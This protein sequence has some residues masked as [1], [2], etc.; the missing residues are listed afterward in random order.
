MNPLLSKVASRFV[1]KIWLTASRKSWC[2][3]ISQLV[4]INCQSKEIEFVFSRSRITTTAKNL[5]L[6]RQISK[7]CKIARSARHFLLSTCTEVCVCVCV[8]SSFEKQYSPSVW[9]SSQRQR[10]LSFPE[11]PLGQRKRRQTVICWG[12]QTGREKG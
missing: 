12:K 5:N 10:C 11:E 2:H 8:L 1:K 9:H 6:G 7:W 4:R 3:F